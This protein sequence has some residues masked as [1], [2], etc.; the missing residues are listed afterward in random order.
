MAVRFLEPDTSS[1]TIVPADG[2]PTFIVV[3][4]SERRHA[5]AQFDTNRC[6]IYATT[7]TVVTKPMCWQDAHEQCAELARKK[8]EACGHS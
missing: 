1:V 8:A 2:V 4:V 6:G 3:Q 7:Y 5:V